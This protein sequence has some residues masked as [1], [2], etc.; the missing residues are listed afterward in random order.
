MMSMLGTSPGSGE[1]DWLRELGGGAGAC[2]FL[3]VGCGLIS[4]TGLAASRVGDMGALVSTAT[5]KLCKS[6]VSMSQVPAADTSRVRGA[7]MGGGVACLC[8]GET[9]GFLSSMG[10]VPG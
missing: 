1:F 7:V 10:E 2:L 6:G 8:L 3:A 4:A 9:G 5:L